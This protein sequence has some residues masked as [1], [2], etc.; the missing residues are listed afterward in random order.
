M[1]P[2]AETLIPGVDRFKGIKHVIGN[3]PLLGINFL[4]RGEPRVIYAKAEYINMTGSIKDRMA[5]HVLQK[6]YEAGAIQPGDT[7]VEATSGNTGISFAA[8]GKALGHPVVIYMPDWMSRERVNLL[9]SLG[10]TVKLVSR[11]EGGFLGSIAMAEDLAKGKDHIFLP[12]QFSNGANVSAHAETTGPEIWWQLHFQSIRPTAF[13]AGVGTGGTIM[14]V[15]QFLRSK[16]PSARIS[17]LQPAESPTLTA[18]H[19]I[20]HHRIQGI[21]DEFIPPIVELDKLDPAVSVH[22]GDSI[23]MAQKLAAKLGLAV[24]ISSGANFIGALMVQNELGSEAVV[25]T[26]F[27]D[28]NKK[29]LSTD[30]LKDEEAENDYLAP[31]VELLGYQAYKRVCYTCCDLYDCTQK[32]APEMK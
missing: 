11:D 20:G 2:S 10:A 28:D 12:R 17:P 9:Q 31:R 23:I 19:K 7:I 30:L 4:Y 32:F 29:Y 13:V 15:G 21:S 25:T 16:N 5:F 1:S 24:G 26:V 22:D 18:G 3:T 8:I 27:P 6:A 14:D